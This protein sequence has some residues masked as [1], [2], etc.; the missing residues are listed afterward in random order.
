MT[1]PLFQPEPGTP[2]ANSRLS[3]NWLPVFR[4]YLPEI[5]QTYARDYVLFRNRHRWKEQQPYELDTRRY[6]AGF[7]EQVFYEHCRCRLSMADTLLFLHI[8]SGHCVPWPDMLRRIPSRITGD[9]EME[10]RFRQP[11][12]ASSYPGAQYRDPATSRDELLKTIEDPNA[13]GQGNVNDSPELLIYYY[14][15]I[16]QNYDVIVDIP[17]NRSVVASHLTDLLARNGLESLNGLAP[18]L[19]H[20]F[21]IIAL[22]PVPYV[23]LYADEPEDPAQTHNPPGSDA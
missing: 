10:S 16:P 17:E 21:E 23:P 20:F 1:E 4:H 18:H 22:L 8:I 3:L 12:T 2:F 13:V 11:L 9:F 7:W 14:M 6:P 5:C 15:M 19:N